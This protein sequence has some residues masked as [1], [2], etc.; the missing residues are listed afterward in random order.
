MSV[1]RLDS[2]FGELNTWLTISFRN[3]HLRSAFLRRPVGPKGE[4]IPWYSYSSID[5]LNSFDF[6]YLSVLEYGGGNSSFWW[7]ARCKQLTTV[8]S[9]KD[10]HEVL[11]AL[12]KDKPNLDFQLHA[13]KNSY[14]EA[15]NS[16]RPNV[17]VIDGLYR[18]DCATQILKLNPSDLG[19]LQLV[20]FDNSNW[21]PAAITRLTNG[22]AEFQ[23][24]DFS[25]L[26]PIVAFPTTTS[27]FLRTRNSKMRLKDQQIL[28]TGASKFTHPEDF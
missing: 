8:E 4:L 28:P 27:L 25:G 15:L 20:I 16:L 7:A 19:E 5:Y 21:F 2:F 18:S 6:E 17:V 14:L 22:L 11:L 1:F 3:G 23:R 10:W 13:T 9:E 12:G 26:G 24:V